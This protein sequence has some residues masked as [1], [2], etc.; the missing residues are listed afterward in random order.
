MS[1]QKFPTYGEK[2]KQYLFKKNLP[3]RRKSRLKLLRES[4]MMIILSLLILFINSFIPSKEKLIKSFFINLIEIYNII[5][6]M[7]AYVSEVLIVIFLLFSWAFA[8][9]LIIGSFYRIYR[10]IRKRRKNFNYGN[11]SK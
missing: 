5:I 7:I 2:S 11:S 6:E 3:L 9:I 10:I 1:N 8:S 4:L